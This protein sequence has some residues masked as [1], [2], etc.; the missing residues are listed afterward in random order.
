LTREPAG[1]L[2]DHGP[3]AIALD[4]IQQ[5]SEARTRLDGIGAYRC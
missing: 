1:I 3:H 2:N 5:G 4:A